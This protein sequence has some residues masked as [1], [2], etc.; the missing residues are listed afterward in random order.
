MSALI[1]SE[2]RGEQASETRGEQASETEGSR[3]RRLE[4]FLYGLDAGSIRTRGSSVAID[5][6]MGVDA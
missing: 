1:R 3:P 2:T 6:L 4:K 5:R